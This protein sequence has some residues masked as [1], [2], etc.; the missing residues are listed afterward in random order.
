MLR[1]RPALR[2][3]ALAAGLT[4]A[5]AGL[6]GTTAQP[7]QAIQA[8]QAEGSILYA[9]HPHAV[10]GSYVVILRDGVPAAALAA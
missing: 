9:G 5:I 2:R 1:S 10:P 6:A 8:V 4:T 7:V 3:L